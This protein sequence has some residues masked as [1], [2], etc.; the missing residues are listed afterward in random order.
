ML[1]FA[2]QESK[3]GSRQKFK[4]ICAD[5]PKTRGQFTDYKG[6]NRPIL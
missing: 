5:F 4:A 6:T 3:N 1:A 2:N